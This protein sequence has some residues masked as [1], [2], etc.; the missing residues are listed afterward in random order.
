M[1]MD[2]RLPSDTVLIQCEIC[3]KFTASLAV[4]VRVSCHP[5]YPVENLCKTCGKPW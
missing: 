3:G 1:A 2:G 4:H 5:R